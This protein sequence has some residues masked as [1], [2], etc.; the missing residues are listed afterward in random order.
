[1]LHARTTDPKT[2]KMMMIGLSMSNVREKILN[3][4]KHLGE[5][6]GTSSQIARLMGC[7]RDSVSPVMPQLERGGLITRTPIVRK[8]GNDS[9]QTV[10]VIAGAE[11]KPRLSD[12]VRNQKSKKTAWRTDFKNVPESS[13]QVLIR[14][15]ESYS[16][17]YSVTLCHILKHAFEAGKIGDNVEWT[18]L[19]Q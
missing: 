19:P 3:E 13:E 10:W 4:L 11:L 8:Q 7:N 18:E 5:A 2:S 14:T 9:W 1:M 17:S 16:Y 12:K 15:R 6:G